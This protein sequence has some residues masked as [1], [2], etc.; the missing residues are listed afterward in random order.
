M[1]REFTL[2]VGEVINT[3]NARRLHVFGEDGMPA[4][5]R[6]KLGVSLSLNR[7][8]ESFVPSWADMTRQR[9]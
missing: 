7:M 6:L 8:R 1:I 3:L 5:A 9:A 4:P 2:T